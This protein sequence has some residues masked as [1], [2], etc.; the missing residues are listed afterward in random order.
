[1]KNWLL[2]AVIIIAAYFFITD[3]AMKFRPVVFP[4]RRRKCD[5]YG[6]GK[7]GASRTT[8]VHQGMDVLANP[9]TPVYAAFGGKVRLFK[10]YA[11]FAG[12]DGVEIQGKAYKVKTMYVAPV[13]ENGEKVRAGQLIG[14]IQSLDVK[15]PGMVAAGA[16]HTH[17]EVWLGGV[18]RNPDTFFPPDTP[19]IA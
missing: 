5:R 2:W 17:V 14:H 19:I 16:N 6:C 4:F 12:L 13:V 15:Y 9:G 7:F 1:M 11:G 8:H 10:P 3:Y 18:A